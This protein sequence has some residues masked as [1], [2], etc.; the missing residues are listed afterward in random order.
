M[1]ASFVLCSVAAAVASA[2]PGGARGADD[3]T[4]LDPVVITAERTRQASFASPAAIT[5]ITR[6]TIETGG[7]QVNLSEVLNRVPGISVLN[8]Q[9]YAQDLQLSIRGFGSR[10]TFGIRG[11]RLI[12]DG[13]PATMPD[14]QGQAS[15]VALSSA[16]RIE[17][18]RGPMA[19]L[20]GNAA[21]GVVQIFT[22]VD[23][24]TPTA[25]VSTSAGP[26]G[27]GKLGLKFSGGNDTDAVMLDVS[28]YRT[29]GYRDHSAARRDQLNA[30]W[31]H[32]AG[33]DTRLSLVANVLDQPVSQDPLGLTRADWQANPKQ[34]IAAATLQDTR[35]TV[36]Q[37]QLGAVLE[38]NLSDATS[39]TARVYLGARHL[40]NA[41]S[42]P[43]TAQ[44]PG[45]TSAGGIVD[46]DRGYGGLGAQLNHAV[47]LGE[48][49]ALRLVGGIEI[50]R[51]REMRRGYVNEAGVQAE[52]K[53]DER[54]EVQNTDVFGQAG[55][56]FNP[57]WSVV[58]GLRSSQVSFRSADFFIR[59]GNPDDSGGVDY[60][61]LNPVFGVSWRALP[62]LNLYA[63]VGR[64]F[65]TPTFTELA[66]RAVG[67]GLNTALQAS[68]SRHSELGAKWLPAAG[69]RVDFAVFDIATSGEIV[70]NTNV[71]GR[72]TFKNAGHTSR[73]GIELSYAGQL[74]ADWR[75]TLS[76]TGLRAKFSDSFVSGSGAAAVTV[77]AGNRLPG[78][79]SRSAFAELAWAP[80]QAWGGFNAAVE[81]V[82]TG[83]LYVN[84]INDDAAPAATVA[85]LRAGLA[86][87]RG[88]W[89]FSERLRID[90][91]TDRNYAG[92]VIVNE[93]NRRY[94]EPALPRNWT[95]SLTASY[96]FQ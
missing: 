18:L 5:A 93:G 11:V 8:R 88:G 6:D 57:Q 24:N 26:Y 35:K 51:M 50:D 75:A 16:A 87:K 70:V 55:I 59:A 96:A 3:A 21:G 43:L 37:Q 71:G 86:Q 42:V 67:T 58:A 36:G 2:F 53:R 32:D 61:A 44:R 34:A 64:G 45:P 31:Q 10:S 19:Q 39:L 91:L 62:S 72:S 38:H 69:H 82:H 17:V 90:N 73:F 41:L 60:R 9:N 77:P 22:Q 94:F 68:R 7:P 65:E 49:S 78:T 79:P 29:S 89:S 85:N 20:Y 33:S 80:S 48:G 95:L 25:T 54:N 47:K 23:N 13:I 46:F 84:D 1:K 40:E 92:S 30:K 14:G 27:Q 63:N 66:Y 4:Q 15:S 28:R 83:A 81:L 76:V 12:V 56:D 74:A 52:L